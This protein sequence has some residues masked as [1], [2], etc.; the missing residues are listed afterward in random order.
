MG[1]GPT[2]FA[3]NSFSRSIIVTSKSIA[4]IVLSSI[5]STQCMVIKLGMFTAKTKK[6]TEVNHVNVLQVFHTFDLKGDGDR[7][8][9]NLPETE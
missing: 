1:Q 9:D 2:G 7:D 4:Y 3:F 8:L 5:N 6:T